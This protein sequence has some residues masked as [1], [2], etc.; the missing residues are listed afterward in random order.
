MTYI[1]W[2]LVPTFT[3]ILAVCWLVSRLHEA[4]RQP[5]YGYGRI[6]QAFVQAWYISIT[7]IITLAAWL[8]YLLYLVAL[9]SV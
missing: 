8:A 2:W 7:L 5:A 3:T 9:G 1:G 4:N 6:G